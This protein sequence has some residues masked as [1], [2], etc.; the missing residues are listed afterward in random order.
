VGLDVSLMDSVRRKRIFHD[1]IG[2]PK[3]SLDIAFLPRQ[4][5]KDVAR[6]IDRMQ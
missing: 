5:D 2:V 1:D 6:R 3:A 4:I